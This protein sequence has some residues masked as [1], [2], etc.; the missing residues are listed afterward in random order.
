[1]A[2]KSLYICFF[3][4][5]PVHV[6]VPRPRIKPMPQRW[7][8]RILNPLSHTGTLK[9]F[10]LNW[11]YDHKSCYDVWTWTLLL[12]TDPM[13]ERVNVPPVRSGVLS[14]P[15]EPN[16]W[17]RFNSVA[18]SNMEQIWTFFTLGTIKPWSVSI[19]TPM[20]WEALKNNYTAG[21]FIS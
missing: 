9:V 10:I 21:L 14:W 2:S 1:M 18:T 3:L 19:A 16:F 6:E 13:L 11:A 7:Q 12:L 8:H 15:A 5:V 20:L 4:A 17:R